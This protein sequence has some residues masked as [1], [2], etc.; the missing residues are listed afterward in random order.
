MAV[1]TPPLPIKKK[2]A[3]FQTQV[4]ATTRR[5]VFVSLSLTCIEIILKTRG[6]GRGEKKKGFLSILISYC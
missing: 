4:S 3:K 6:G 5:L 1:T 2:T